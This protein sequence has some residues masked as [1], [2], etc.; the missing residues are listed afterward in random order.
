M[1]NLFSQDQP[2]GSAPQSHILPKPA[3]VTGG[4]SATQTI[5]E[6]NIPMRPLKSLVVEWAI[7][8]LA[9]WAFCSGILDVGQNTRL[10][11]NETEIIQSLDWTLYNA[12]S[13]H[14]KFPLWNT[15]LQTG[16]PYAADPMLHIYNPINTLPVLLL[17]VRDGF[18]VGLCLS[19][20][21]A[22][23]G[24]WRLGAVL[25]MGRA[26]RLWVALM[27]AFAGQPVARFFQGQYLFILGFAWIPWVVSSLIT[28]TKTRRRSDMALAIFSLALLYF[29]GNAYYAF[30]MFFI[31][32]LYVLIAVVRFQLQKPFLKIDF[33][34][35]GRFLVVSVLTTGVIAIQLLP[36]LEFSP[37]LN[38]SIEVAGSHSLRQIFWD[39]TSKDTYRPDAFNQLPAR[40]EFYAYIGLAP[41]LALSLLPIAVLKRERW[42]LLFLASVVFFVLLW[43]DPNILPWYTTFLQS[44]ITWQ[45]RHLLRILIYGSLALIF[46]AG[47][48]IDTLWKLFSDELALQNHSIWQKLRLSAGYA[49]KLALAIFMVLSVLDLYQ[50]H[51]QYI[52]TQPAPTTAYTAMRWLRQYDHSEYFVRL[53][54]NNQLQDAPIAANLRFIEAWYHFGDIRALNEQANTRLLRAYPNY[55]AQHRTNPPPSLP[56]VTLIKQIEDYH[57]YQAPQSLPYAFS[58]LNERLQSSSGA[59]ELQRK[60]VL[61]QSAFIPGPN[62]VEVVASGEPGHTLVVLIS[63]YPGW[64]VDMDGQRQPL[65]NIGGYLAVDLAPGVHKYTFSFRPIS[66]FIG[67]FL[68]TLF[69]GFTLYL[70]FSDTNIN[71]Q[72]ILLNLRSTSSYLHD[73]LNRVKVKFY[74]GRYDRQ[75]EYRDGVLYPSKPIPIQA[76][77]KVHIS[78][79]VQTPGVELRALFRRWLWGTADLLSSLVDTIPTEIYFFLTAMGIYLLT[80]LWALD[81]FPIYFF[82]DEAVQTLFAQDLLAR[83]F[84]GPDGI[85]LPMYIEAAALR[86]TPLLSMYIQAGSLTLFG[87]SILV[88]RGTSVLVGM[89]GV[90]AVSLSLKMVFK[91]RSWWA[92]AL[93]LS[94]MPAWFLHSR[95]AFETVM[96][97]AFYACFLLSYMLY[98]T[99]SARYLYATILFAAATF[100]TYS[101]AQAIILIAAGLLLISD[102]PYHLRHPKI[103]LRGALLIFVLVIPLANFRLNHPAAISEHLRMVG[104]Y[105]FQEISTLEKIDIFI[106]KYAYSL[107]PQYWF[108]PNVHDLPRH[109]MAG[110]GHIHIGMLLFIVIGLLI[111][112]R[113]IKSSPHR[114][115]L[116]AALATPVGAALLDIGIP[117]VLA[118]VIPASI[119]AGLGLEWVLDRFRKLLN[120][121]TLEVSL[122]LILILANLA[123]LQTALVNGPLW[124]DDYG[125][126]GMQYGASQL[127]EETIPQYL[128][129]SADYQILVSSTWAN[130]TDNF[131]RFFLSPEEQKRV[132]IDGIGTY[133]FKKMPLSENDIF[134]MTPAEYAQAI[135]S[136]KFSTVKVEQV[137]PYPDGSPGFYIVKLAYSEGV[138]QIFATEKEARRQLIEAQ[139]I[140]DG[141]TVLVRHSQIDMGAVQFAFDQDTFTLMRGLEANPFLL[142]I[143]F[144][145]P[146]QVS[147]MRA[148]FGL[149]N[150]QVTA[151]LLSS[152]EGN[153]VVYEKA[154]L[155]T[156]GNAPVAMEFNKGPDTVTRIKF[157]FL[158]VQSGETANIHIRELE[159]LP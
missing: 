64:Q 120:T 158:N 90:L 17:G 6:P 12:L 85:F 118:F 26:G 134:I 125:L 62:R 8:A 133:L 150:I 67:L 97:T 157:E 112:L 37:R 131:V 40:E 35:M 154:F 130:G 19:F 101:N 46:L 138:D 82:G 89:L 5:H 29:S 94:V 20:L 139:V 13:L 137:I 69:T 156:S 63:K 105:W 129:Q 59:Q 61:P 123:L 119:L 106:H 92:G 111:S 80:R 110:M 140:L 27:V 14:G 75:A 116:I 103:L 57:I 28:V 48:G 113:R 33:G 143:E 99:H 93:L 36:F 108:I 60:D 53:N 44:K 11:G 25:G 73:L 141:E 16:L 78:I 9:V 128:K 3:H 56:E 32:V 122:L 96:M 155:N 2:A 149:V 147:S 50:T 102:L 34:L 4:D 115:V 127:F 43:I 51:R 18:K 86:W 146:R 41:I 98:R 21:L 144:P 145:S 65:K 38:A 76:G 31:F 136:P 124:F 104:S 81:K 152:S 7:I 132:R 109:R 117:R 71:R 10:P 121:R 55:I 107:S 135:D 95:T 58:V 100:Y 74:A 54:P 126:Y 47:L 15:Y 22:A 72:Q 159:L 52:T 30:Y 66:F 42:S 24:A 70:F 84:H 45:F 39:Y 23:L 79:D 114:A 153:P 142:E 91:T 68:S 83:K 77:Q 49:G 88:T 151:K 87:K 148:E 1:V